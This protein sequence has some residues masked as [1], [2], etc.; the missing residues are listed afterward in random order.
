MAPVSTIALT[1]G[2]GTIDEITNCTLVPAGNP[3]QRPKDWG[4]PRTPSVGVSGPVP[5]NSASM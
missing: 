2:S 4:Q 1:L 3:S 5:R